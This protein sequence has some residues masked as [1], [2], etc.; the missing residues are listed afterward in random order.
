MINFSSFNL[1]SFWQECDKIFQQFEVE[2]MPS[3][4]YGWRS[5]KIEKAF[6]KHSKNTLKWVDGVGYDFIGSDGLK[7]EFKQV[8]D[9]FKNQETP[10]IILKNF[11][12]NTFDYY[13]QTF[14]YILV[15]DVERRTLGVYD[16]E[17]VC[18]RHIINS[19]TV[20]AILEHSQARKLY[21]PYHE[22]A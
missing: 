9:A 15:I 2:Q 17:Y 6:E 13:D 11:R 16:W 20:T 21:T 10:N 1:V 22:I 18:G 8:K 14:D 5:W 12:K 19:A 7:Y 3:E 4:C